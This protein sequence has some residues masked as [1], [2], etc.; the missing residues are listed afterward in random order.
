VLPDIR[1]V[2]Q[3]ERADGQPELGFDGT[4]IRRQQGIERFAQA[5]ERG[6]GAC[7]ADLEELAQP[8]CIVA[9]A[10]R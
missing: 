7:A 8:A 1:C 6:T 4:A 5:G 3:V 9:H 2:P 10:M